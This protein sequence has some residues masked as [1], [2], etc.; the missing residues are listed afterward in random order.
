MHICILNQLTFFYFFVSFSL[1][2]HQREDQLYNEMHMH[3]KTVKDKCR[4]FVGRDDLLNQIVNLSS[5][6]E[7]GGNKV[8]KFIS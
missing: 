7:K 6:S 5:I 3:W 4:V 2:L 1:N 8:I